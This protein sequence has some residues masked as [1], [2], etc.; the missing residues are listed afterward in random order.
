MERHHL[1]FLPFLDFICVLLTGY[2]A[3]LARTGDPLL[4]DRYLLVILV[5]GFI[6]V[7]V[8]SLARVYLF[9]CST[10]GGNLRQL[11]FPLLAAGLVIVG[12]GYLSKSSEHF[13]RI[14]ATLWFAL[15]LLTMVGGRLWLASLGRSGRLRY[16]LARRVV[17]VGGADDVLAL[18][19]GLARRRMPWLVVSGLFVPE[20]PPPTDPPEGVAIGT[21]E[22][23]LVWAKAHPV[24][25][26]VVVPPRGGG[27]GRLLAWLK[28]LR[29]IPA[30]L[31]VG[32]MELFEAYPDAKR[33]D[34]AG[35]PVINAVR[36][37]LTSVNRAF[38]L[39]G[40]LILAVLVLLPA[41]PVMGVIALAIRLD[42]PGPALFR[43]QRYG[44]HNEVFTV[45]KFRTMRMDAQEE[46]SLPQACRGD[47][48]V[49]RLGRLLRRFSLDEL[50]QL[51]NVL[52][53][54]MSLVGP[55]PHALPHN[56]KYAC[57]LDSYLERH[58]VKPGI[59]GWAQVN[60]HRGETDTVEKMHRRVEH[61][62][63]YVKNW[64]PLLDFEILLRT[65]LVVL[66]GRN[67]Y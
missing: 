26:L 38:K 30:N 49:T 5:A 14:W 58:K 53:G 50:P 24:D 51:F 47:P 20:G 19:H 54:S 65:V 48:R 34:I 8:F 64:S 60:G 27:E 42:S 43:Q 7:T 9:S 18:Y 1:N 32:P 2:F 52:N 66:S 10:A 15:C 59:T 55:R 25:D 44:F 45:Y 57:L 6:T 22:E 12:V 17:L 35:L 56:D 13:S 4:N 41:L 16:W 36:H 29:L 39:L 11:F 31:H 63:F 62:L 61:D 37:P 46:P 23:L 28:P 21:T 33:V 3:Y 40:D 67:A